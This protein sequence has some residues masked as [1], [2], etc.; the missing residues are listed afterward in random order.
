MSGNDI[1]EEIQWGLHYRQ[2]KKRNVKGFVVPKK[3]PLNVKDL[4]QRY[5][6]TKNIQ[7]LQS[8]KKRA[9]IKIPPNSFRTPPKNKVGLLSRATFTRRQYFN[10]L[11]TP[12]TFRVDEEPDPITVLK[13]KL[14]PKKCSARLVE[15]ARPRKVRVYGTWTDFWPQL[16]GE[17]IER[18]GGLLQTDRTLDPTF[19]RCCF[20]D[21]DRK[22]KKENRKQKRKQKKTRKRRKREDVKWIKLQTSTTADLLVSFL[23]DSVPKDISYKQMLLSDTILEQLKERQHL[24]SKPLRNSKNVY[25][26][27]IYEIVDQIA[28]WIDN[29][30]RYV[31][32]QYTDSVEE[33]TNKTSFET[34]SALD[35]EQEEEGSTVQ[36]F[37]LPPI[38]S[39]PNSPVSN[40]ASP[41]ES[42][43]EE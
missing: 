9:S 33:I 8:I 34:S 1:D 27:S 38:P 39:F 23:R 6:V 32:A 4:W 3:S 29:V 41:F 14:R 36:R 43:I 25:Q 42:G 35:E 19:A 16:S 28:L 5:Q 2:D 37:V 31:D 20:S 30:A 12:S 7:D 40:F 13:K 18:L 11:A 10:Y 24:K 15:L 26:R 21:M 22:R 17:A